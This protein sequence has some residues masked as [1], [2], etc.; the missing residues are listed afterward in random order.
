MDKA[1]LKGKIGAAFGSYGWGSRMVE[2]I[3]GM[4]T[5]LKFELLDL[6]VAK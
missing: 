5:N 4:I 3:S 6:V 1:G 2:Q